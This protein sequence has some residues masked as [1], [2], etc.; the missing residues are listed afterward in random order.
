MA[1]SATDYAAKYP[2]YCRTCQG[3]GGSKPRGAHL[4]TECPDCFAQ[5][6]CARCAEPL[7]KYTSECKACGWRAF[8]PADALPGG[9]FA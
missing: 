2:R 1:M 4:P 9:D 7:A 6:K 8:N 5:S 3:I